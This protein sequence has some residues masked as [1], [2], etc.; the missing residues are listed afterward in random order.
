[1]GRLWFLSSG[2]HLCHGL[3][4]VA[5]DEYGHKT[6]FLRVPFGV[7]VWA[8]RYW[9]YDEIV[10]MDKDDAPQVWE[11]FARNRQEAGIE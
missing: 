3:C 10:S 2:N 1:M 6:W 7:L 4:G 11:D 9:T 8:V 5:S